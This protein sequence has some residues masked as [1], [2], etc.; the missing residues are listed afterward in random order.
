MVSIR[1]GVLG[2]LRP[3][4]TLSEDAVNVEHGFLPNSTAVRD[5]SWRQPYEAEDVLSLTYC[6]PLRMNREK[7]ENLRYYHDLLNAKEIS[8]RTSKEP[9]EMVRVIQRRILPY[10][11]RHKRAYMNE[12]QW[13]L[14]PFFIRLIRHLVHKL[15]EVEGCEF[16]RRYRQWR[17]VNWYFKHLG[18]L[19][20]HNW[21]NDRAIERE[22]KQV[23]VDAWLQNF[24]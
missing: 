13:P 23:V 18:Q 15:S 17:Y 20:R 2:T 21:N 9:K 16:L 22:C 11:N 12:S 8:F 7:A 19:V 24:T 6:I 14:S 5:L 10:I 4:L 3:E 1:A